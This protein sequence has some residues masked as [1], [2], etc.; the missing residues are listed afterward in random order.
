MNSELMAQHDSHSAYLELL[1]RLEGLEAVEI[2][3]SLSQLT[4]DVATCSTLAG[5]LR[6]PEG[7]VQNALDRLSDIGLV[8]GRPD[9]TFSIRIP[10]E[11]T[12]QGLETLVDQYQRNRLEIIRILNANAIERI[13]KR[14][15]RAFARSFVLRKDDDG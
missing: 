3:V 1:E 15:L 5:R 10:D 4:D 12:A 11:A 2:I 13:R 14:A 9:G 6:L 8:V 7:L